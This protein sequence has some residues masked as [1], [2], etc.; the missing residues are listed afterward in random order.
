MT[1]LSSKGAKKA[2][3]PAIILTWKATKIAKLRSN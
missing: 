1:F 3:M 2:R